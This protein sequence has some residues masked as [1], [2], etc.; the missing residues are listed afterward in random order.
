MRWNGSLYYVGILRRAGAAA[1]CKPF[2]TTRQ[3]HPHQYQ[4]PHRPRNHHY[5]PQRQIPPVWIEEENSTTLS[6]VFH[7][8]HL[9]D[10]QF[11]LECRPART[12]S[13][14][15]RV[16]PHNDDV[17]WGV[18]AFGSL[19]HSWEEHA[20]KHTLHTLSVELWLAGWRICKA[21]V[22]PELCAFEIIRGLAR[23]CCISG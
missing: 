6:E 3:R 21:E 20:Q 7:T 18:N 5:W 13:S 12:N 8:D 2:I 15:P 14:C 22:V 9:C 10:P 16:R 19:L 17:P 4:Q 1:A 11:T 23:A